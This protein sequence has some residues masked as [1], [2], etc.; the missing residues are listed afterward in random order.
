MAFW[1]DCLSVNSSKFTNWFVTVRDVILC[2]EQRN[3]V[4]ESAI[5]GV[6]L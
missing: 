1:T 4:A 3:T 6:E 5:G 2:D